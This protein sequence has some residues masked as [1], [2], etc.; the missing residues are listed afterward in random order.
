MNKPCLD[1][2]TIEITN[3]CN[4]R[5][6]ICGIGREKRLYEISEKDFAAA[7]NKILGHFKIRSVSVTGGEPF[8]HR[9]IRQILRDLA[10]LRLEGRISSFGVYTNGTL[11]SVMTRLLKE[12]PRLFRRMSVGISIDGREKTHDLRRGRGAYHKSMKTVEILSTRFKGIVDVELKFTADADNYKELIDVYKMAVFYGV[13]FSPKLAET[14]VK[15]YYHRVSAGKK[16]VHTGLSRNFSETLK[17]QILMMI[18]EESFSSRKTADVAMLRMLLRLISSGKKAIHA[19]RTPERC[20][21]ITSRGDVYPC[22]YMTPCAKIIDPMFSFKEFLSQRRA[23]IAHARQADCPRCF[24]Y[25]G[26]LKDFN[27]RFLA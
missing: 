16:Q 15:A 2:V 19:C 7:L 12:D 24:A 20:L 17:R 27:S 25:H 26:F 1:D 14:G 10:L 9:G 21:F 18:K 4:L 8:L 23:S 13:R 22:L 11:T 3:H 6:T 5:C